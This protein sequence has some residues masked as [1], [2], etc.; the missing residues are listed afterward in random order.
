MVCHETSKD[1]RNQWLYP[2]EVEKNSDGNFITKKNK[3]RV[4]VGPSEAMSK[5]RKN[6]VD[7]EEMINIYGADSIRWF[8]LSDSPP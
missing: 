4:T 2:Y 6:I 1:E 8:M 5:S 7:P 3:A